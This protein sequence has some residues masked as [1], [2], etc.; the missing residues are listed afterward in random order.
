M[1]NSNVVKPG[2]LIP[3]EF[4]LVFSEVHL[5]LLRKQD[6]R[7]RHTGSLFVIALFC[8][9]EPMYPVKQEST[10]HVLFFNSFF[11]YYLYMVRLGM[12]SDCFNKIIQDIPEIYGKGGTK[13]T[14]YDTKGVNHS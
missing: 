13:P 12:V 5:A 14:S 1:I 2:C 7:A 9:G 8:V 4:D 3:I 11:W 10:S 6:C